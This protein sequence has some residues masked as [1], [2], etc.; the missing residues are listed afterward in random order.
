MAVA[1]MS[2]ACC[3]A[4]PIITPEVNNT[5][6]VPKS[7]PAGTT[8]RLDIKLNIQ[9]DWWKLLQS[10]QLNTLIELGFSA[11]PTLEGAQSVLLRLQHNDISREGYFHSGIS[12]NDAG[13]GQGRLFFSQDA[14]MEDDA[15]FIGDSYYDIH[16]WQLAVGYVPELLREQQ[17]SGSQTSLTEV[18]HLQLE[19]TYR[20]LA[21]NLIACALQEASLRAQMSVA[22]KIVAIEQSRLVI[23]NK[24][25]KAGLLM[26]TDVTARERSLEFA[27]QALRGLQGKFE[28][29]HEALH[30]LLNIP[31]GS[32]LPENFEL[33]S[34]NLTSALPLKLSAALVEQRPDVRAAQLAMFPSNT[35]YLSTTDVAL[36]NVKRVLWAI[37][38]DTP[39]FQAALTLE[40][41][42]T[43]ALEFVRQQYAA[44]KGN[45]QDVLIAQLEL[46]LATLHSL[47]A[48]TQY[49]GDALLLYHALGGGWWAMDDALNLESASELNQINSIR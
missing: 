45:Y 33:A 22:R 13:D 26:Q 1:A 25:L 24:Q 34:L 14:A 35:Q 32:D 39:A 40:Q 42:K 17:H 20:T 49:L 29:I 48:R 30:L 2:S 7:M 6:V 11:N 9:F 5:G 41:N 3:S 4:S 12:V 43:A 28:Q 15:K 38:N 8:Q 31:A 37:Q 46:Q 18:R 16:V 19:A 27:A 10:P 23:A 47:Q 36:K 21:G 44:N